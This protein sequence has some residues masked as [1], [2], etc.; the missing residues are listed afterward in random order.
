MAQIPSGRSRF[1]RKKQKRLGLRD[2]IGTFGERAE[3][4][5]PI[6]EAPSARTNRVKHCIYTEKLLRCSP[7]A[8]L[9]SRRHL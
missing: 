3:I 8:C 5:I 2:S 7:F 4:H 6:E 9:S 1:S